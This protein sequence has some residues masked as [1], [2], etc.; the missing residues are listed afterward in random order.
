MRLSWVQNLSE[1]SYSSDIKAHF[2]LQKALSVDRNYT[3]WTKKI[4]KV[5]GY[6]RVGQGI[7]YFTKTHRKVQLNLSNLLCIKSLENLLKR[8]LISKFY[9]A[10]NNFLKCSDTLQKACRTYCKIFKRCLTKDVEY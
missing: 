1:V 9:A 2:K 3:N 6:G 10:L 7:K 4:E 8:V 5:S